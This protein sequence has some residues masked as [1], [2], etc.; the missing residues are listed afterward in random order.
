[1]ATVEQLLTD[2]RLK[3]KILRNVAREAL[4]AVARAEE[5]LINAQPQEAQREHEDRERVS[6]P[7]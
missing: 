1:M 5:A 3:L 7:S 2:A 6:V 4:V